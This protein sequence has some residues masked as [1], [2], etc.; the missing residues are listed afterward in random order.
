MDTFGLP[1]NYRPNPLPTRDAD[2]Y[3]TPERIRMSYRYQ[4]HVYQLAAQV[5]KQNDLTL[6]ADVG[7]GP[8]TKLIRF[9]PPPF[10]IH[11]FD[12]QEAIEICRSRQTH[13]TFTAIDLAEPE[14]DGKGYGPFD[15]VIC[16]DVVEHLVNPRVLLS[17]LRTLGNKDTTYVISTPDRTRLHGR[18][19]LSPINPEHIREWNASEFPAFV[20]S[21]GFSVISQQFF[22]LQ[23]LAGSFSS[24]KAVLLG[25]M[26]SE[27][28]S[29]NQVLLCKHGVN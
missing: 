13:G 24:F 26:R 1:D 25:L 27:R 18:D 28:A 21:M 9:F 11:G 3:W 4:Y 10:E 22:P 16:A 7:C 20:E 29:P 8:G 19:A 5:A 17:Y 23:R 12:L 15:L 2:P 6:I 14:H